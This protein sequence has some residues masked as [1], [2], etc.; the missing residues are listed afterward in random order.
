VLTFNR[1]RAL[2][3]LWPTARIGTAVTLSVIT[4]TSAYAD[5]LAVG[6]CVG[7]QGAVNCVVRVGPAGDPYVRTVPQPVGE[8]AKGQLSERDR[9]WM[10]RCRPVIT[11]DRYGVPRYHYAAP[12]CEFGVIE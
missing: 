8:E 10:D 5:T 7:G 11:Q 1:V 2:R 4:L 3:A 9:R 12:G 6:G